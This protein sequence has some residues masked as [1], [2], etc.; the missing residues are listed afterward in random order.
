MKAFKELTKFE[1][2]LWILSLTVVT[3]SFFAFGS[4]DY[5]TLISSLIGVTALIF[6]AKGMVI[7]QVLV[8]IFSVFY[9]IVSYFFAYYGEMITYLGMSAPTA[10][11]SLIAWIK[12]PYKNTKQVEI[13][14]KMKPRSIVFLCVITAVATLTF[15]FIL[16]AFGNANLIVSTLSVATSVLASTLMVYRSPYYAL[17]YAVNDLVLIVLWTLASLADI[18]YIPMVTCFVMFFANDIYGFI[19]WQKMKRKQKSA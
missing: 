17:A 14:K 7:G 16:R 9:G 13:A 11:L 10:L 12:H 3:G 4:R 5:L 19:N 1:L 6:L 2:T 8:I 18:S 15:Y